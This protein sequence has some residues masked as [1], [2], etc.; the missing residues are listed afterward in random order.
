MRPL[1]FFVASLFVASL[2]FTGLT[3]NTSLAAGEADTGY[4][5]PSESGAAG[6]EQFRE[7]REIV[8]E[9]AQVVQTMKK[10]GRLASLL[11]KA[12][13]LFIVPTL[14]KGAFIVGGSGGEGVV[15]SREG[16]EWSNPAFYNVGSV[17]IGAQAGGAAGPV[18]MI[19]MTDDAMQSFKG[20]NNFSLGAEAG[21]TVFDWS[22]IA[23]ANVGRGDVIMW[24]GKEGLFA[25]ATLAADDVMI[26]EEKN[27]AYYGDGKATPEAIFTGRVQAPQRTPLQEALSG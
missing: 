13:G 17:S 12:R 27:R 6:Q 16:G 11:E 4:Q 26:D 8:Q 15:L 5:S 22:A 7:A 19:L 2:A 23:E 25:G 3:A 24:S 20:D 1:N 18:A 9:A 21:L 10:D 14:V